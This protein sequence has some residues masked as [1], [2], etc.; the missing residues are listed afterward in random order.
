MKKLLSVLLAFILIFS[1]CSFSAFA[2]GNSISTATKI[3]LN[4]T[5]SDGILPSQPKDVY[6]F[7]VSSGNLNINILSD[8]LDWFTV[9][10]Y[11]S[12]NS[13]VWSTGVN[14]N[15][16]TGRA[17]LNKD[18][19]LSS[20]TYYF[21]VSTGYLALEGTYSFKLSTSSTSP[22]ISLSVSKNSVNIKSGDSAKITC[23]YSGNN[24]NGVKVVYSNSNES[25]ASVSWGSWSGKSI[26]M[27]INGLSEGSTTIKLTIK[28]KS[29]GTVL[30]TETVKVTVSDN[31]S[32]NNGNSSS[33]TG[34][35]LFDIFYFIIGFIAILLGF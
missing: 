19:Y 10:V 23:S 11:D 12:S 33:G 22:S 9:S 14:A 16:N 25:V 2:A 34:F 15:M 24:S 8:E 3:S 5:Y 6:K 29:T 26:P 30:D 35:F 28:D 21:I 27:T 7:T 31:D 32:N 4:K 17:S 20:G 1:V 13:E 18:L